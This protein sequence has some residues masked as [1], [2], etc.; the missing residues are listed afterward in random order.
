MRTQVLCINGIALAYMV[1][2][3]PLIVRNLNRLMVF[4]I[5]KF[6]IVVF[7]DN[8]VRWRTVGHIIDGVVMVNMKVQVNTVL[9]Q[10][11]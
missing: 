10:K 5:M 6:L 11:V 4:V 7:Q 8:Q 2:Q 1:A 3:L 9:S